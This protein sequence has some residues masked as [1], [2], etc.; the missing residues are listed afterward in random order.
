MD[1]QQLISSISPQTERMQRVKVLNDFFKAVG[2]WAG[3]ELKIIYP[4]DERSVYA[5][6]LNSNFA[7]ISA[8]CTPLLTT[9]ERGV[10]FKILKENMLK[11]VEMI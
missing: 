9:M 1:L 8:D 6:K 11:V 10:F 4:T 2:K 7:E 3:T 5:G